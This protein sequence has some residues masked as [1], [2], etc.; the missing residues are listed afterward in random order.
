M[1]CWLLLQISSATYDKFCGP[2]SH[3]HLKL[4]FFLDKKL[5]KNIDDSSCSTQIF[6]QS[7]AP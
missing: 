5:T 2:G 4:V 7:G 6:D 3:I 1:Y